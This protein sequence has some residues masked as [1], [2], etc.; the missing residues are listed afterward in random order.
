MAVVNLNLNEIE[1]RQDFE[2]LPAGDY[3]C[4]LTNS[5]VSENKNKNG[6]YVKAEFSVVE[7]QFK[8]MKIWD[9]LNIKHENDIAERIGKEKFKELAK[10][11]GVASGIVQ[12]TNELHDIPVIVRLKN[13]RNGEG[14]EVGKY[15]AYKDRQQEKPETKAEKKTDDSKKPW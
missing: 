11:C 6:Y 1:D 2:G 7:G 4:L 15:I 14:T 3:P 10:A 8:N 12:D 5:E 13:R 9:Y